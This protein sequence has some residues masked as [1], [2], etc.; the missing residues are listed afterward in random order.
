V[1]KSEALDAVI[2]SRECSKKRNFLQTFEMMINFTGLDMKK[3]TSLISARVSMPHSTGQI[4][5]KILVFAKTSDFAD[6]LKDRVEKI[7]MDN[8][9]EEMSKDKKAMADLFTYDVTFAEGPAMLTVAKFMGQQL[10]PKGKMPKPIMGANAFEETL[11]KTK[12]ET[13]ITNKKAKPT[14]LVQVVV[15]KE[16]MKNEALVENM[17]AAYNAIMNVLPQK[18]LNIK[19]IFV[20]TTMGKPVKVGD[21]K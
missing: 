4:S 6:S 16:D 7:I 21:K 3:P 8:E 1:K 14:P 9:I 18:R 5:G 20:K 13:L 15:G 2:K 19:S 12:T 10:A 17:L 11:K